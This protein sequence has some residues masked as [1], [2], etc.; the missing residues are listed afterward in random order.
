MRHPVFMGLREDKSPREV[1]REQERPAGA[2]LK[3]IDIKT[4]ADLTH[5]DKVFWPKEGFTKKDLIEY[6]DRMASW[7]LPYLKDRP[8][9]LNRHPNG[10]EEEGFFQKDIKPPFRSG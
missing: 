7:I 9:S 6:Y 1:R 2:I 5:L 8:Q 10:I 3:K 4:K